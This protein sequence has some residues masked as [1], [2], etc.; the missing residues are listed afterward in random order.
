[1]SDMKH[2]SDKDFYA[3]QHDFMNQKEREIFLDHIATCNYCADLF[4][5]SM[6]ED[7]IAAPRD[8]KTNILK[9]VKRPE[10]QLAARVRKTSKRMQLLVY[11][12]KVGTATAVAL[13]LLLLSMNLTNY[14]VSPDRWSDKETSGTVKD[15]GAVPLTNEIRD[16]MDTICNNI[17]NFSN[18]IMK[19]EV[20]NNEK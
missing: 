14:A 7:L 4:A 2:I 17:L 12:L 1:M 11:S 9:A 5:T 3:F 16:G 18:T 13:L 19:T 8:L 20:T 15:D 10:V 6:S